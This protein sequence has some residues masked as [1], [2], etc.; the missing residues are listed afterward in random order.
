[1]AGVGK[2]P[3]LLG[4]IGPAA[5]HQIKAGQPVFRRDFLGADVLLH[6]LVVK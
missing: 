2:D 5:I 6:R 4:Q 1:M 3:V